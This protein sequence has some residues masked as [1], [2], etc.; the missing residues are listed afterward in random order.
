[1]ATTI[2]A[3]VSKPHY[4][5][6]STQLQTLF[7]SDQLPI[8]RML[9]VPETCFVYRDRVSVTGP[10]GYVMTIPIVGPPR[11]VSHVALHPS[12]GELLGL[13]KLPYVQ[14]PKDVGDLCYS[15][16][17]TIIGPYGEVK[18]PFG[19]VV[20]APHIHLPEDSDVDDA[21]WALV[22]V[23]GVLIDYVPFKRT[24]TA[25]AGLHIDKETAEVLRL[26]TFSNATFT[27]H[28]RQY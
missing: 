7:G 24:R 6:L 8:K 22:R 26:G 12:H 23:N 9:E 5:P 4:H 20:E 3:G 16:G 1:M 15:P 11:S 19:A 21:Q 27:L 2:Y 17:L 18:L 28:A 14:S 10:S 13:G 25:K